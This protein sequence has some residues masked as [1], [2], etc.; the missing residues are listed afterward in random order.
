MNVEG[1]IADTEEFAR[2]LLEHSIRKKA[3]C[4]PV[5]TQAWRT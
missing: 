1:S 5:Y 2:T 4:M 3:P